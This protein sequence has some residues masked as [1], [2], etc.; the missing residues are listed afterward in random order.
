MSALTLSKSFINCKSIPYRMVEDNRELR[1]YD[2]D[3]EPVGPKCPSSALLYSL[4]GDEYK[5]GDFQKR[6]LLVGSDK[7]KD[8]FEAD[9]AVCW[10]GESLFPQRFEQVATMSM[11]Q[12]RNQHL[13]RIEKLCRK[14]ELIKIAT[15][16]TR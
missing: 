10:L 15:G 1:E 13:A 7:W 12:E 9:N 4:Q 16:H 6:Q 3:G 5:N 8:L 2:R 14:R 11:N